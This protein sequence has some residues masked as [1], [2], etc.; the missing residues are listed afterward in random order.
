MNLKGSGLQ[1][2]T[3]GGGP[4]GGTD[5]LGLGTHCGICRPPI[6]GF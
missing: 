4:G 1:P 5:S 6:L 3:V 2:T